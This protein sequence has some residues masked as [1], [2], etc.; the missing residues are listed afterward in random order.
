HGFSA[1]YYCGTAGTSTEYSTD[2]WYE[3]LHRSLF[4]ERLIVQQRALMDG[5]DPDRR[6]GLIVDEWGT[7][8]PSAPGRNPAFL[9]QQ[10][11]MRDALVAAA[12]L[13]IFNRHADKVVMSNIAQMINVLQAMIL[14]DG[15][16]MTVTPTY[17][18]YRMYREHHGAQS[19][20]TSQE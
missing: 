7:W 18:V 11:T 8:H 20:R 3:L 6:I 19:L 15:P 17:H 4:M 2:Q 14:T 9:W 10:N 5:Y 16:R 12:T 1:H 13:D